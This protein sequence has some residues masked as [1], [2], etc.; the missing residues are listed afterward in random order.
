M[1]TIIDSGDV[2]T[3]TL[4]GDGMI[5]IDGRFEGTIETK[6]MVIIGKTGDVKA[7]LKAREVIIG[8]NLLGNIRSMEKATIETGARVTGDITTR[9]IRV[10][11]GAFFEGKCSMNGS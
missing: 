4:K 11:T 9:K 2:C 8:G 3:G 7:D 6:D 1:N 5:R 10:E